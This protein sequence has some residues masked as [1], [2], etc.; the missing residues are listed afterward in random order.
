M[1]WFAH[2]DNST[3]AAETASQNLLT[4]IA[5]QPLWLALLICVFVLA[6][7]FGI[8]SLFRL[9]LISKLLALMPVVLALAVMFLEH[10]PIVATILLSGGFIMVFALAFTMLRAE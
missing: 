5:H 10:N 3:E 6:G 1:Q 9:K 4:I 8:L 7:G 2:T